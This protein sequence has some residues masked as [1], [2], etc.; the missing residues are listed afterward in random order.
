MIVDFAKDQLSRTNLLA[1]FTNFSLTD[2]LLFGF[3]DA[4]IALEQPFILGEPINTILETFITLQ[5][6]KE[7]WN[8]TIFGAELKFDFELPRKTYLTSIQT[9]Y[10]WEN[11]EFIYKEKYIRSSLGQPQIYLIH[12]AFNTA[13]IG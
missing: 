2:T 6:R 4:R 9:F 1:F 7:E 13:F 8:A 3:A 11:A 12:A 5:K 10:K